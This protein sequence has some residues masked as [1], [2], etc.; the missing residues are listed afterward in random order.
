MNEKIK[1]SEFINKVKV[2]TAVELLLIC[3]MPST[4][5]EY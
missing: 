3:F 4:I 5:L 1:I 2:N